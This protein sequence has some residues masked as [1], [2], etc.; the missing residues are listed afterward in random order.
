MLSKSDPQKEEVISVN[1]VIMVRGVKS[2][3][4]FMYLFYNISTLIVFF[5]LLQIILIQLLK[6]KWLAI[7]S[8][9]TTFQ[10]IES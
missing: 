7:N 3:F 8:F 10:A 4:A 2:N 9:S 5:T 1:L 6:T